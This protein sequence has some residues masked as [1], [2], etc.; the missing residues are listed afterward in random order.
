MRVPRAPV[1]WRDGT[2]RAGGAAQHAGCSPPCD[3]EARP[4]HARGRRSRG[5]RRLRR[6]GFTPEEAAAILTQARCARRRGRSS[7]SSPT[8][9][10]SP[11]PGWSRRPGSTSR[12][13][14]RR[15]SAPRACAVVAD[16]GCGIG[17]DALALAAIGPATCARSSATRSPR[18]SRSTTS[19][20]SRRR[21][22]SSGD[23]EEADLDDVDGAWLDPARRTAGHTDTRRVGAADYSP[24]LGF[25]DDVADASA[26]RGEARRPRT[27]GRAIPDDAE[28]QWV[29]DRGEVV[30]LGALARGPAA[31]RRPPRRPRLRARRGP[32]S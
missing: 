27:I 9:C 32:R 1:R 7:A 3:A 18:R 14:T 22:W 2:P 16:L 21:R 10:C 29:S 13:G 5:P 15:A 8:G 28:A 11:A 26:D 19:P 30:E 4:E 25:A 12:P 24:S 23:A 17:G 20:R 31:R 6:D